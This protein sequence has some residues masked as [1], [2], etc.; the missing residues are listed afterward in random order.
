M[1]LSAMEFMQDNY[2][3]K[4][5]REI[6]DF[7]KDVKVKLLEAKKEGNTEAESQY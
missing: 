5:M 4:H 3:Y 7:K 2:I 6:S 1:S